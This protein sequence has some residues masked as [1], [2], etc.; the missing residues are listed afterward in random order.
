[1][2]LIRKHL[3]P[4]ATFVFLAFVSILAVE[5]AHHHGDLEDH[6]DCP[7]CAWQ[8]TTS[9]APTTPTPPLILY[10]LI[11]LF[12]LPFITTPF[13]YSVVSHTTS[14]LSP[15]FNLG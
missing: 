8:L 5:E 11:L 15:P 7:L 2:F 3:S 12:I 4:L 13:F 1:M 6:D 10:R 14:G 9:Q